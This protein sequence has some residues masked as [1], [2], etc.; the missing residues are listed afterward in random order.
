MSL[1]HLRFNTKLGFAKINLNAKSCTCHRYF[2]KGVCKHLVAACLQNKISLPGLEQLPKKFK[3]VRRKKRNNYINDS[4]EEE[5]L[6]QAQAQEQPLVSIV[7]EQPFTEA[8]VQEPIE[9]E[10]KRRGRKPKPAT[11]NDTDN[12]MGR[13]VLARNALEFDTPTEVVLR[14]SKRNK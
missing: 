6:V 9:K 10:K 5:D 13:P 3:L 7:Q 2:D 4:L 12:P 14:R 8:V 1:I 11:T